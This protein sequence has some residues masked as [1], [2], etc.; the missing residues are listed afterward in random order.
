LEKMIQML[1]DKGI[2][3]LTLEL[4][5]RQLDDEIDPDGLTACPVCQALI[6]NLMAGGSPDYQVRIDLKGP[7]IGIGAPIGFF[8]PDA[9][10]KT[11]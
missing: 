8:L 11:A 7:V 3:G 10:L 5:K 1:L 2:R 4:L 6:D 9:A